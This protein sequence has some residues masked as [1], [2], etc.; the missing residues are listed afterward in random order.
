MEIFFQGAGCGARKMLGAQA[1]IFPSLNCFPECLSGLPWCWPRDHMCEEFLSLKISWCMWKGMYFSAAATHVFIKSLRSPLSLL[2]FLF[3]DHVLWIHLLGGEG[4][5]QSSFGS[6]WSFIYLFWKVYLYI[7]K[8]IYGYHTQMHMC[9]C[10]YIYSLSES[11][12]T[13]YYGGDSLSCRVGPC[14]SCI[15]CRVVCIR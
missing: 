8:V 2:P 3:G 6:G 14:Y 1:S 9:V 12:P 13:G 7:Y 4:T 15:A 5:N 10:V 11:F